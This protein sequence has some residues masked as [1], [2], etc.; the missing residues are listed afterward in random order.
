MLKVREVSFS[1]KGQGKNSRIPAL[2]NVSFDL[3]SGS[4][5]ILTGRTG[6]GKSTLLQLLCGLI[7]PESGR[8]DCEY[9]KL[10]SRASMIFQYPEE[11]FFNPTV[12]EEI[13][14][15]LKITGRNDY[16]RLE[17]ILQMI[18][19]ELDGFGSRTPFS[20]SGGEQRLLAIASIVALDREIVLFDEP[21]S[22][23]DARAVDRVRKI[24]SSERKAGKTIIVA[25]HWPA[26]FLDLA[27][28]MMNL[29]EGKISH[30]VTVSEYVSG[31]LHRERLEEREKYLLNYYKRFTRFPAS[32][33]ELISFVRREKRC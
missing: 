28:H 16:G 23:L 31:N 22:G 2:K 21:T 7:E 33:E 20:L 30:F 26:E 17:D 4:F 24:L 27:T 13:E 6:S 11:C 19:F 9:G 18:G 10:T 8:I 14:F 1:Y 5:V 12:R 15:S 29:V 3:E 32:E 25:T